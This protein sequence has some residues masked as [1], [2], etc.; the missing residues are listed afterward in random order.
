[1]NNSLKA[2]L[3]GALAGVLYRRSI[4]QFPALH[5]ELVAAKGRLQPGQVLL[6]AGARQVVEDGDPVAA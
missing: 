3:F 5:A 1:M 6:A 4:S 2:A